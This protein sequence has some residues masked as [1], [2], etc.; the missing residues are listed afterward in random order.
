MLTRYGKNNMDIVHTLNIVSK[1]LQFVSLMN[2]KFSLDIK[3]NH[4]REKL[5]KSGMLNWTVRCS[6]PSPVPVTTASGLYRSHRDSLNN[7]TYRLSVQCGF[8]L[9]RSTVTDGYWF[10]VN[11]LKIERKV[12]ISI[13]IL[14]VCFVNFVCA[15]NFSIVLCI[16]II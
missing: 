11:F 16:F 13:E 10:V 14:C 7:S 5:S 4:R 6:F 2:W 3:Q 1:F 9:V 8:P 12:E 15:F